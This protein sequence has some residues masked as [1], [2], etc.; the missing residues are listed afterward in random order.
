MKLVLALFSFA[1]SANA[2]NLGFFP[3]SPQ[4][5]FLFQAPT[6]VC[7]EYG[8]PGCSMDPTFINLTSLGVTPGTLL[9][10]TDVGGL[11]VHSGAGCTTYP[12]S[13]TY[14]GAVFSSTNTILDPSNANRLPNQIAPSTGATLI[15]FNPNL[16]T[17]AGNIPTTIPD[18]FYI[19]VTVVVPAN[20]NYL[21]VGVLDSAYADNSSNY[22]GV[23]LSIPDNIKPPSVPEPSSLAFLGMAIVGLFLIGKPK[24]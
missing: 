7:S 12:A 2:I 11:C 19:S 9:T 24:N 15:G 8:I 3:V 6:D 10:I 4:G 23:E 16:N 13:S 21:V 17:L 14:M 5:T 22:L 20:A 1:I 18:D